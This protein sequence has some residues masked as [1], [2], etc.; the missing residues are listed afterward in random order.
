MTTYQSGE[1]ITA[2][3]GTSLAAL[4]HYVVAGN[5]TAREVALPANADNIP[6]GVLLN[7]PAAD[8][9]ATIQRTGIA[10]VVSNGAT[11]NIAADD[12]V[13]ASTD[14]KVYKAGTAD[15]AILGHALEASSADGTLIQVL[16]N[17][18]MLSAVPS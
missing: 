4:K 6:Y 1:T 2:V 15:V 5:G 9:A 17:P 7:E 3:A 13:F 14:G 11:V 18:G 8:Q 10:K 16:L 12:P